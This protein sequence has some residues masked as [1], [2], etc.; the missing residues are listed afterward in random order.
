MFNILPHLYQR[1]GKWLIVISILIP[2]TQGLFMGYE[3][4]GSQTFGKEK[5]EQVDINNKSVN[6]TYTKTKS[7]LVF[8][9]L[10]S[11]FIVI[12]IILYFISRDKISD[13][14]IDMLKVRSLSIVFVMSAVIGCF[15][16]GYKIELL[17]LSSFQVFAYVII[18]KLLKKYSV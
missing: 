16:S 6:V 3:D 2:F 9:Y 5:M 17:L 15:S 12:G 13:E 8:E 7:D 1:I 11:F 14:Y 4:N 18:L 10:S